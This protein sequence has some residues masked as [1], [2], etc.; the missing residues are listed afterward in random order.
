MEIINK[1]HEDL[2]LSRRT[3]STPYINFNTAKQILFSVH[4]VR[5][6][7]LNE[8]LYVHFVNDGDD[9]YFYVNDD[10]DGFEVFSREGKTNMFL[11]NAHLVSLFLKRT[12]WPL[13]SKFLLE[14]TQARVKGSQ[15]IKIHTQKRI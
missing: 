15:L 14:K 2:R 7:G 13:R 1:K 11:Y 9:W 10:K 12:G 6:L 5:W 8:G 4:A 3:E